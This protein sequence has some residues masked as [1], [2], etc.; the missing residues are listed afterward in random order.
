MSKI[1]YIKYRIISLFYLY[2]YILFLEL[3]VDYSYW[4]I[5]WHVTFSSDGCQIRF[6]NRLWTAS[7]LL[8]SVLST[9]RGRIKHL[10]VVTLLRRIPPPL[11]FGKFC[12]HRIACKVRQKKKTKKII[13]M[14]IEQ[15]STFSG[16][17]CVAS[18]PF[19]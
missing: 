4:Q 6:L 14:R 3:F 5:R 2:Y 8:S 9:C 15:Q 16:H 12:P 1:F 17:V 19:R 18:P 11:G 7:N 13:L 10:D